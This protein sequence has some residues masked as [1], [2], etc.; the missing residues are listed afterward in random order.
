VAS[1][2]VIEARLCISL[3][4]GERR[5]T[6]AYCT[7]GTLIPKWVDYDI[8]VFFLQSRMRSLQKITKQMSCGVAFCSS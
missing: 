5:P 1:Q 3:L 6:L 7:F 8:G 4:A 2:K